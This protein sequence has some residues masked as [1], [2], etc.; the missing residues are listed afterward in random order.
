MLIKTTIGVLDMRLGQYE[1]LMKGYASSSKFKTVGKFIRQPI[2][3]STA[4]QRLLSMY[5]HNL[6]PKLVSHEQQ[7]TDPLFLAFDGSP[8]K[9]LG[10]LVTVYFE[11]KGGGHM[12]TTNLRSLVETEANCLKDD[13]LISATAITGLENISGHS[14]RTAQMYYIKR[15]TAKDVHN[16]V[17]IFDH[18]PGAKHSTPATPPRFQAADNPSMLDASPYASF[19]SGDEDGGNGMKEAENHPESRIEPKSFTALLKRDNPPC[20][21]WGSNH[22]QF[23][24]DRRRACWSDSELEYLN[25]IVNS[26]GPD[27]NNLMANCL[28]HIRSDPHAFPIFH[29]RH[30][31]N[32]DRLKNG[33]ETLLKRLKIKN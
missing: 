30:V 28:K 10:R 25:I 2:T 15:R 3:T 18:F 5:Y 9:R 24:I 7:P 21:I 29:P 31:E 20:P 17:S 23:G 16:A 22:P 11:K 1:E 27:T 33:Y 12:T 19:N 4:S 32:S 13:G 6:R 26:M 8:H 14:T